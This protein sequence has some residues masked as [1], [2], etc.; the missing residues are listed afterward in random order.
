M[1]PVFRGQTYWKKTRT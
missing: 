1:N